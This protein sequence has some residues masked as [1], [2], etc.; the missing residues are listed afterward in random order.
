MNGIID[1][2]TTF[3]CVQ[4]K[5][6]GISVANAQKAFDAAD[7]RREADE[8]ATRIEDSVRRIVTDLDTMITRFYFLKEHRHMTD[9]QTKA[10]VNFVSYVKDLTRNVH[11]L[12]CRFQKVEGKTFEENLDREIEQ[13]EAQVK[14]RLKEF[15]EILS[16]TRRTF[17]YRLSKYVSNRVAGIKKILKGRTSALEEEKTKQGRSQTY[18][19]EST[20]QESVDPHDAQLE[21]IINALD[22]GQS[23]KAENKPLSETAN[24]KEFTNVSVGVV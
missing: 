17:K 6:L 5:V 20:R 11:S 22:I 1:N 12:L 14:Q 8:Q 7:A 18:E 10:A 9:Y 3:Y 4:A 2:I 19:F 21:S 15:D 13:I 16:G 23:S 24:V